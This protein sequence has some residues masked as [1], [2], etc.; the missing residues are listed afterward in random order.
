MGEQQEIETLINEEALLLAMYLRSERTEWNA[1]VVVL[2]QNDFSN[3][4]ARMRVPKLV[5]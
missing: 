1:R 5:C 3:Q 4:R 2:S